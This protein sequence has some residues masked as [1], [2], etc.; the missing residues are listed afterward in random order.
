MDKLDQIFDS[1]AAVNLFKNKSV[2]QSNYAPESILH[3]AEQIETIASIL[4]PTLRGERVSNLFGDIGLNNISVPD[5]LLLQYVENEIKVKEVAEYTLS[6]DF[7]KFQ[8]R[9]TAFLTDRR[10]HHFIFDQAILR[11]VVPLTD[12]HQRYKDDLPPELVEFSET[13]I[14]HHQYRIFIKGIFNSFRGLPVLREEE[15]ENNQTN[16]TLIDLLDWAQ[17]RKLVR[18]DLYR[19]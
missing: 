1:F 13:Q 19:K 14:T 18:P 12:R 16:L 6:G 15:R 3:R 11:F 17:A 10:K 4:G 7:E 9:L 5:G 8:K 2:L